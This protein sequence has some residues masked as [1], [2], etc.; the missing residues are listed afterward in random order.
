MS[1]VT[2]WT[3]AEAA[4]RLSGSGRAKARKKGQGWM[5]CCPA[6][7]DRTPSLSLADGKEGLLFHCF[8]GC[9]SSDVFEALREKLGGAQSSR[10]V[11]PSP[12]K[13]ATET[14]VPAIPVP[15]DVNVT[16][17][18]FVDDYYGSPSRIWTYRTQEGKIYGWICR[19]DMPDGRKEVLPYLWGQD[20]QRKTV[21]LKKR[22]FP[23][24]RPLYQLDKI[25]A[26]PNK[27]IL[28]VEGE[29]AADAGQKIFP[30]WIVTT[31]QGGTNSWH[32]TDL[33]PLAGRVV[34]FGADNDAPGYNMV[35]QM[36]LELRNLR[37][38]RILRWPTH[39]SVRG[40]AL[41]REQYVLKEG[42]DLAD[43]QEAGWTTDLLRQ[44][45]Q[46]C[47]HDLSE[48]IET[49]PEPFEPV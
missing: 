16:L 28:Y 22:G 48:I 47:P 33:S 5:V 49:L 11:R 26:E 19:Y 12:K 2:D 23:E 14:F 18:D 27:P 3:A 8:A 38:T 36:L 13:A 25:V 31:N 6:H 46:D 10:P 9:S 37:E 30:N 17:Q 7:N 35:L 15:D 44:A 20:L 24:K 29:K 43:H 39:V 40:G 1:R 21:G 32:L 4:A 42:C 45:M 41:V 34:I